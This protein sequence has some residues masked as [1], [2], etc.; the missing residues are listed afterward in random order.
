MVGR[1]EWRLEHVLMLQQSFA[2]GECLCSAMFSA[3]GVKHLQ[4]VFYPSGDED[5][6]ASYCSFFLFCSGQST[7]QCWLSVGKQR[8]EAHRLLCKPDFLG[9]SNFCLFEG[10]ADRSSDALTLALEIA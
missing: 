4:L 7:M 6:R 1:V 10:C 8:R 2:K 5:A 9:R 3:G